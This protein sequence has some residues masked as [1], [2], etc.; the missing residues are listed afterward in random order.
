MPFRL[1]LAVLLATGASSPLFAIR[2]E[3]GPSIGLMMQPASQ[4]YLVTHGAALALCLPETCLALSYQE[5]PLFDS[6]GYQDQERFFHLLLGRKLASY[7]NVNLAGLIG[8]GQVEGFI[9]DS[10]FSRSFQKYGLDVGMEI[11]YEILSLKAALELLSTSILA[12]QEQT[13]AFVA[14]PYNQIQFSVRA[15]L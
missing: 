13:D 2:T 6:G 3:V 14:W 8:F 7:F 12:D 10:E 11:S 4:Y 15:L 9:R 1:V 5:R